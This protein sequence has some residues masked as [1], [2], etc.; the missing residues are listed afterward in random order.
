MSEKIY[1]LYIT[2]QNKTSSDTNYN[3]NLYLSNYNINIQPDEDAYFHLNTFQTLNSFYNINEKSNKFSIKVR[4]D[5]DVSFT[6]NFTIDEG[7]YN[8]YE[9]MNIIN[10]LAKDYINI[11]YNERKNKYRYTSTQ[12]INN[13]VFLQP[14]KYNYKYFG[15]PADVYTEILTEQVQSDKYSN[16]I[17]MNNFSLIIIKVIGLVEQNKAIDNFNTTINK[18]DC[19]AIINRQDN[20]VGSLINWT[21]INKSFIKKIQNNEI[22]Q[23]T[24]QFYN[25]YNELLEDVNEWLICFNI[26]IKK[27][28]S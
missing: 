14:N 27:K 3:Y 28:G 21:D 16:I 17:N 10:E 20:A 9:F 8:I 1:N 24:F 25:E 11:S 2:S 12:P 23:L 19:S 4:T 15:Y 6:Y 5:Q 26:I 18:G 7:N 22:N 13:Q